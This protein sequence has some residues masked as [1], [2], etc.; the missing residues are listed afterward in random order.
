[1]VTLGTA[2]GKEEQ[3]LQYRERTDK[4]ATT[5]YFVKA[6]RGDCE[7]TRVSLACCRDDEKASVA[8]TS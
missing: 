3:K 2:E 7:T 1:M 4:G 5:L 8:W 6:A